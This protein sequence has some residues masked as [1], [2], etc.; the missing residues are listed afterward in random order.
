MP[1]APV[2]TTIL[3][4]KL[5]RAR[6][7]PRGARGWHGAQRLGSSAG[8]PALTAGSYSSSCPGLTRASTS[9]MEHGSTWMAGSSPAMTAEVMQE[10]VDRTTTVAGDGTL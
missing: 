7:L 3:P 8:A 10:R 5:I 2:M 6:L 1:A 4:A 9:L